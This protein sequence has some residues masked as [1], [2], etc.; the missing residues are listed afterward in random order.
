MLPLFCSLFSWV[1]SCSACFFFVKKVLLVLA[2]GFNDD[3]DQ[4]RPVVPGAEP[5]RHQVIRLA[6]L[7]VLGSGGDVL[8]PQV[9]RAQG[10][11]ERHEEDRAAPIA[12][13]GW[14]VTKPRP[15]GPE[16]MA[17]LL[18][19]RPHEGREARGVDVVADERQHSR[20]KGERSE[21]GRN[22]RE[23]RGIP[24]GGDERDARDEKRHERDYHGSAGEDDRAPGRR[25]SECE[26]LV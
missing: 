21:N 18:R 11:D 25:H 8:L 4:Q 9:E 7:R 15:A 17:R 26:R 20:Q 16:A 2:G 10:D 12:I 24:E 13:H 23:G 5:L 1:W 6:L 19:L 22:H 3:R 14:P